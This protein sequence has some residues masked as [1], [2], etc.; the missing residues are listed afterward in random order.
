MKAEL[1]I[2]ER[3][4]ESLYELAAKNPAEHFDWKKEGI[5]GFDPA[6][7]IGR[8]SACR[9][10]TMYAKRAFRVR[11]VFQFLVPGMEHAEETY[12]RAEML[13]VTSDFQ[14]RFRTGS[15]QKA[16]NGLLV[17]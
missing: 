15:E 13:G 2:G 1:A 3:L 16:V 7:V 9:D 10:H 5:T 12:F 14:E 6:S 8:Q 11:M 17:L 4:P